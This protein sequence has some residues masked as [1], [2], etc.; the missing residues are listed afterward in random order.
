MHDERWRQQATAKIEAINEI[1][2]DD[3]QYSGWVGWDTYIQTRV[4]TKFLDEK[5][6][7]ILDDG[8]GK[9]PSSA[10][11]CKHYEVLPISSPLK[12]KRPRCTVHSFKAEERKQYAK[13]DSGYDLD[14]ITCEGYD[15]LECGKEFVESKKDAKVPEMAVIPSVSTPAYWCFQCRFVLCKD[16]HGRYCENLG[17]GRRLRDRIP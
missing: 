9:Q 17:K 4:L 11:C 5:C 8:G 10:S 13:K 15:G 3:S 7:S 6:L 16:C 14:G 12:E 1:Y 2:G